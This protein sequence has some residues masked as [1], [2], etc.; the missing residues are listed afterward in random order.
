MTLQQEIADILERNNSQCSPLSYPWR[1]EKAMW[2]I[3]NAIKP[4]FNEIR[5]ASAMLRMKVDVICDLDFIEKSPSFYNELIQ[6]L[7]AINDLT[8][9]NISKIGTYAENP[10]KEN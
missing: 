7:K 10:D 8:D 9:T 4:R 5:M 3:E 1:H 2:I 6:L